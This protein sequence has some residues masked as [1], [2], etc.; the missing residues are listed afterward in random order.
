VNP[1]PNLDQEKLVVLMRTQSEPEANIIRGILEGS[2][3]DCALIAQ[4]PHS[5][6]PF[7]V[8]GLAA[9]QIKVL[10]SKLEAAQLLLRD[11]ESSPDPDTAEEPQ[12]NS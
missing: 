11:Y 10:A 5:V 2:G 8:D 4:V 9:I 6:Y 7:T 1:E 3:I 12:E